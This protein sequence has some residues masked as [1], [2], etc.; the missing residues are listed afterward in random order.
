MRKRQHQLRSSPEA[1]VTVR[2]LVARIP[3]C[4]RLFSCLAHLVNRNQ[5]IIKSIPLKFLQISL[6]RLVL[7]VKP[8]S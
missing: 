7:R 6:L 4:R 2:T 1:T 8:T 5:S 3:T